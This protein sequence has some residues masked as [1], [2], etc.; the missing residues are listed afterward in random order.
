MHEKVHVCNFKAY[1]HCTRLLFEKENS[2]GV[3]TI[4]LCCASAQMRIQPFQLAGAR[5][6]T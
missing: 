3:H 6:L 5:T 4:L 1:L 2:L